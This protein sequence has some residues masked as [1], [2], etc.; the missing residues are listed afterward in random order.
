MY[1]LN[2]I[3]RI[4]NGKAYNKNVR[5]LKCQLKHFLAVGFTFWLKMARK[6]EYNVYIDSVSALTYSITIPEEQA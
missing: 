4:M 6:P 5:A 1:G 3:V 2:S